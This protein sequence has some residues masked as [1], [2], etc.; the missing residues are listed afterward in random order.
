MVRAAKLSTLHALSYLAHGLCQ[1]YEE[2]RI[3]TSLHTLFNYLCRNSYHAG[4]LKEIRQLTTALCLEVIKVFLKFEAL[5]VGNNINN[6]DFEVYHHK[7]KFKFVC[8]PSLLSM[9]QSYVSQVEEVGGHY[10]L[11]FYCEVSVYSS[12]MC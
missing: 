2:R 4:S 8:I 10:C 11:Y 5:V 9:Q 1:S 12:H 7:I 3:H 6:F